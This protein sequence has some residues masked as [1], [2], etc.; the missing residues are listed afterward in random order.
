MRPMDRQA[1][2]SQLSAHRPAT[3]LEASHLAQVLAFVAGVPLPW[4]RSTVEGHLTASAWII[5]PTLSRT[6]LVH[7]RKLDRWLQPGGHIEDDADLL[8]ASVR[9]ARE[10]CG[11]TEFAPLATTIFDIDVHPIP[12][13]A[14]EPAHLHY[15]IRFALVADD[16]QATAVSAE[17]KA[18]RWFDLDEVSTW[19]ID[20]SIT[21]MVQK[22]RSRAR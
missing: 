18:V 14:K 5:N 8:S 20:P 19:P 7:H 13:S 11:L 6:L 17:S 1:I 15:D 10:E 21:R 2:L 22:I 9:E 3:E 4:S 16:T 12:A